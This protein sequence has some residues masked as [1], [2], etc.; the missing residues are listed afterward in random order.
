MPSK[1]RR[2]DA[3][4][5]TPLTGRQVIAIAALLKHGSIPAAAPEV[6]I[7]ERQLRRWAAEPA[8]KKALR[9]ERR[10]VMD[11]VTNKLAQGAGEAVDALLSVI[12][13]AGAAPSARVA[14]ARVLLESARGAISEADV[15]A[16]L[17]RIERLAEGR[18]PAADEHDG[19]IGGDHD[20]D[21]STSGRALQ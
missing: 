6:G 1:S 3:E 4:H 14:A 8:F 19:E 2:R 11:G 18:A 10:H 21:R 20:S 9:V 7:S 12:R 13:N 16:R 5:L 17:E 15:A